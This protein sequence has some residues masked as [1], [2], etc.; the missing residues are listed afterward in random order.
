VKSSHAD[1]NTQATKLEGVKE[2]SEP[3]LSK[4]VQSEGL[5]STNKAAVKDSTG[6]S[7]ETKDK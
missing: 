6:G 7:G 1:T 3:P 2:E 4:R 5:E